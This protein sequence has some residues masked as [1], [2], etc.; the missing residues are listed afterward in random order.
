MTLK[1]LPGAD[2]SRFYDNVYP[3]TTWPEGPDVILLHSTE[4]TGLPWYSA[5]GSAPNIT[6]SPKAR[7][8]WQHFSCN[9]SSRS[10]V[11]KPGGVTTNQNPH[12]LK[13]WALPSF[14]F[15]VP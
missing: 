13:M 10:L 11:D 9:R 7:R 12:F 4:T 15:P 3:G 8:L 2:L 1:I 14:P 6:G 5:G